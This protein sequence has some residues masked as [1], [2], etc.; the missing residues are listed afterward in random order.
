[1]QVVLFENFMQVSSL[2]MHIIKI[3]VTSLL[4]SLITLIHYMCDSMINYIR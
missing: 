3:H 2:Y 4:V 1:M